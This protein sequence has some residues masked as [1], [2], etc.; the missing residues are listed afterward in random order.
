MTI[1]TNES[2]EL[3]DEQLKEISG[4]DPKTAPAPAPASLL[5]LW[6]IDGESQFDNHKGEID[7]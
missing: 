1:G 4:G 6:G 2:V 5:T 7:Y 3:S